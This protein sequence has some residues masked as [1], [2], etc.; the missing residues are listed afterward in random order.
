[1]R[2]IVLSCSYRWHTNARQ[3]S[4]TSC[5]ELLQPMH[6]QKLMTA[7]KAQPPIFKQNACLSITNET[8]AFW[9]GSHKMI[10]LAGIVTDALV[11]LAKP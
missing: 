8:N 2:L 1:M 5:G 7:D 6:I 4:G 3:G 10:L 9:R 11:I